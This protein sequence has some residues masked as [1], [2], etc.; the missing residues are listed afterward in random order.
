M[1]GVGELLTLL[2][3]R[4]RVELYIGLIQSDI[5]EHVLQGEKC[6]KMRRRKLK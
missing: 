5:K 4:A 2:L 6:S 3:S 1:E